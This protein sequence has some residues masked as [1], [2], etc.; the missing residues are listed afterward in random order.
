MVQPPPSGWR[1]KEYVLFTSKLSDHAPGGCQACG[2]LS[3][4]V[5]ESSF[6]CE[7]IEM[8]C[9]LFDYVNNACLIHIMYSYFCCR[10]PQTE[11]QATTAAENY[12]T[13]DPCI[14]EHNCVQNSLLSLDVHFLQQI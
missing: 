13:E 7:R 5:A 12:Q 8:C 2:N 1:G 11:F 9:S 6:F 4:S 3:G 10:F 14:G